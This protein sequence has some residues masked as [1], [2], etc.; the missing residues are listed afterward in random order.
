ML[1]SR[2]GQEEHGM[3][4]YPRDYAAEG[5]SRMAHVTTRLHRQFEWQSWAL[6]M[7]AQEKSRPWHYLCTAR[8]LRREVSVNRRLFFSRTSMTYLSRKGT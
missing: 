1:V 7:H 3:P 8:L 6:L 5:P 4:E 2:P